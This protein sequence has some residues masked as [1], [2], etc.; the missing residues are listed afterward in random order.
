[1]IFQP[2]HAGNFFESCFWRPYDCV[3]ATRERR[4]DVVLKYVDPNENF[5]T[6]RSTDYHTFNAHL[7]ARSVFL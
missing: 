3:R 2:I 1:M 5:H 6:A 4:N 7:E